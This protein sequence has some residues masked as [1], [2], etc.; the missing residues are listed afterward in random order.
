[1]R[2]NRSASKIAFQRCINESKGLENEVLF[3]SQGYFDLANNKLSFEFAEECIN[4]YNK[5]L[6]INPNFLSARINRTYANLILNRFEIDDDIIQEVESIFEEVPYNLLT[7]Y[8]YLA[9]QKSLGN[10]NELLPE[11]SKRLDKFS[12]KYFEDDKLWNRVQL[13]NLIQNNDFFLDSQYEQRNIRD[14]I[15][16]IAKGAWIP[17]HDSTKNYNW[18]AKEIWK[19]MENAEYT[20]EKLQNS[21]KAYLTIE[22][23]RFC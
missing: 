9:L 2:D 23:V 17:Q 10:K 12:L 5:A 14:L 3:K 21:E 1:M 4:Y 7:A 19:R 20:S 18:V 15:N 6:E 8:N 22:P 13:M 16:N 11:L